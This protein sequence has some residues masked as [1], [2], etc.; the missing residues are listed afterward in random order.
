MEEIMMNMMMMMLVRHQVTKATIFPK[1]LMKIHSLL[2]LMILYALKGVIRLIKYYYKILKEHRSVFISF[3]YFNLKSVCKKLWTLF[4][5]KHPVSL[6]CYFFLIHLFV[7]RKFS[8]V[9][10]WSNVGVERKE[11]KHGRISSRG[12]KNFRAVE[13][14]ATSC[15]EKN[16]TYWSTFKA[17]S[18]C[19]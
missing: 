2:F 16:E 7:Y 14:G 18:R 19:S 10:L 9:S 12:T 11:I 17:S 1:I 3:F 15:H 13:K 4:L 8:I 5:V 6:L